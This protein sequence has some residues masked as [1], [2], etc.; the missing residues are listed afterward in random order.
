[1]CVSRKQHEHCLCWTYDVVSLT[2]QALPYIKHG[3]CKMWL[4]ALGGIER[5]KVNDV[6]VLVTSARAP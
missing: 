6:S 5:R 2:V 1:M 4:V 3:T